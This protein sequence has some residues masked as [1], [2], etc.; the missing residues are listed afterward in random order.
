MVPGAR[1]H[2]LDGA[3]VA[4]CQYFQVTYLHVSYLEVQGLFADDQAQVVGGGPPQNHTLGAK[5]SAGLNEL[6]FHEFHFE[7]AR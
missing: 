2:I 5:R 3:S 7:L 6:L 1:D 4:L